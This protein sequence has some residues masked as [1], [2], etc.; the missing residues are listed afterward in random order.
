MSPDITI[1][2]VCLQPIKDAHLMASVGAV[3]VLDIILLMAWEISDPLVVQLTNIDTE[4]MIIY[5]LTIIN[6]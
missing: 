2:Y 1:H 6:A 5:R 3:L 4:V